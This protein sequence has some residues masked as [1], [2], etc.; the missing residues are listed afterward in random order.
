MEIVANE[1]NTDECQK[2]GTQYLAFDLAQTCDGIF[3]LKKI[4]AYQDKLKSVSEGNFFG[5]HRYQCKNICVFSFVN[6]SDGQT[7]LA[8]AVRR[9]ADKRTEIM[10]L[11][12]IIN[13]KD[14]TGLIRAARLCLFSW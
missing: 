2:F 4:D 7:Q 1:G 3:P 11:I 14:I 8:W 10:S 9:E 12:W 6:V 13:T 5:Y